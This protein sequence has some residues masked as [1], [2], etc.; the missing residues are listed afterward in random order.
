LLRS[1]V[2]F[3]L[4]ANI[5][6]SIFTSQDMAK[7][8]FRAGVASGELQ[9]RADFAVNTTQ[10]LSF[11]D[12][13]VVPE[14]VIPFVG[15]SAQHFVPAILNLVLFFLGLALG[16]FLGARTDADR[17]G[18][19]AKVYAL[20]RFNEVSC[21]T[22]G[23]RI[24]VPVFWFLVVSLVGGGILAANDFRVAEARA[25]GAQVGYQHDSFL[26]CN[27]TD[28]VKAICWWNNTPIV[29]VAPATLGIAPAFD[30]ALGAR[31]FIIGFLQIINFVA[32]LG[33]GLFVVPRPDV[34]SDVE[35]ERY[36]RLGGDP[37]FK[38]DDL[39]EARF[40]SAFGSVVSVRGALRLEGAGFF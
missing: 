13:C 29:D 23:V 8:A 26:A 12:H 38:G 4:V 32:S 16:Q 7:G 22:K 14:R 39:S 25:V 20:C 2:A 11:A 40:A 34:P 27:A 17:R 28:F 3:C 36:E 15:L 31:L 10:C 18:K 6:D 5:I 35:G 21:L 30:L 1:L 33:L 24:P 9:A 37:K 19:A